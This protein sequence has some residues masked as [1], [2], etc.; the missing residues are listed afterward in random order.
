M[1]RHALEL[2]TAEAFNLIDQLAVMRV[3][4][5]VVTGGDPL[6][7][8][9]L[10]AILRYAH[11]RGVRSALMPRTAFSLSCEAL[12]NLRE[13]AL[14]R[15]A[16]NLEAAAASADDRLRGVS[17]GHRQTV[18]VAQWC[19]E[20]GIPFQANTRVTRQNLADLDNLVDLLSSLDVA[21]WS[22]FLPA[23]R[24]PNVEVLNPEEQVGV[25]A[26]I[27]AAAKDVRFPVKTTVGGQTERQI[28][29]QRARNPQVRMEM[30][31]LIA[32]AREEAKE[33]KDFMFISYTGE[34]YPG[35]FL[36]RSAGNVLWEPLAALYQGTSVSR[37]V[38]LPPH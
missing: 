34:V 27:E 35:G 4:Q 11:R 33:G 38:P 10:Y 28:S 3:P 7:R 30:D 1:L 26:E 6:R 15:L 32:H 5:I 25:L 13:S 12:R 36:S 37:S 29:Q 19:H 16:L 31:E 9:D 23:G 2:S 22:V 21:A 20:A 18:R 17:G 8:P 14:T 24:G